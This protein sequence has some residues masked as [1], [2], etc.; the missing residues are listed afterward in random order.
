[1]E[2]GAGSNSTANVWGK[3]KTIFLWHCTRKLRIVLYLYEFD[4]YKKTFSLY[5]GSCIQYNILNYLE[6]I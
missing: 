4:Q 5:R 3:V 1:M 6:D 2:Y